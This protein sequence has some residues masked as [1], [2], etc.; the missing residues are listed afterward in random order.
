MV[1]F[2][3]CVGKGKKAACLFR[4]SIYLDPL[5]CCTPAIMSKHGPFRVIPPNAAAEPDETFDESQD[6][7]FGSTE[8]AEGR[9]DTTSY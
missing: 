7:L 6:P 9:I 5:P 3:C 4:T 2:C 1:T 8:Q